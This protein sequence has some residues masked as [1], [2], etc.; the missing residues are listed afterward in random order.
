MQLVSSQKGGNLERSRHVK[1]MPYEHEVIY[2]PERE[3]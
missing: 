2:K 3:A 1:T